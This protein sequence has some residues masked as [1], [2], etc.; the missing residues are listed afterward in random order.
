[1]RR[2]ENFFQDRIEPVPVD[3]FLDPFKGVEF[4]QGCELP[5]FFKQASLFH[6]SITIIHQKELLY[7]LIRVNHN[8]K[9]KFKKNDLEDKM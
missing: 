4:R 9:Q 7:C 5:V 3:P 1:M 2:A 8:T 6:L